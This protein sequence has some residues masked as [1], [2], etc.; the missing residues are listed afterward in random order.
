MFEN[1]ASIRLQRI[2]ITQ[3]GFDTAQLPA[4]DVITPPEV[5]PGE[6]K[7][8]VDV[9]LSADNLTFST[10]TSGA[11]ADGRLEFRKVSHFWIYVRS[12]K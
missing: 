1:T 3:Q 12:D 4:L 11:A 8:S 5:E 9:D 10:E 6:Q 2:V 7:D